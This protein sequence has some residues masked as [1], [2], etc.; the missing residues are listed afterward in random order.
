MKVHTLANLCLLSVIMTSMLMSCDKINKHMKDHHNLP[1]FFSHTKGK[2]WKG[3]GS[4]P[5][6]S[7]SKV[8][9]PGTNMTNLAKVLQN[10]RKWVAKNTAV[11]PNFFLKHKP[12]QN[13]TYM[14]VGCSDSRVPPN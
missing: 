9:A 4:C 8:T 3:V 6:P 2:G 14:W 10:N 7:G 1:P 5:F 13:P 11:D 12:S